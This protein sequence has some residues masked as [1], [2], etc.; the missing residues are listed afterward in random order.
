MAQ[1]VRGREHTLTCRDQLEGLTQAPPCQRTEG[2]GIDLVVRGSTRMELAHLMPEP[3][4]PQETEGFLQPDGE[5]G[6]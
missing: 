1:S 3:D 2:A 4:P 6:S 5:I